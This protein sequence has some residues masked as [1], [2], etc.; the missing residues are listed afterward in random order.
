MPLPSICRPSILP[1]FG[2]SC[3]SDDR[4]RERKPLC[5]ICMGRRRAN[6][7]RSGL[8]DEQ[9]THRVRTAGVASEPHGHAITGPDYGIIAGRVH[10][11]WNL[12]P[13]DSS[14]AGRESQS[15]PRA[16]VWDCGGVFGASSRAGN[17]E[18]HVSSGRAWKPSCACEWPA[19]RLTTA[20]RSRTG[21]PYCNGAE[22][23]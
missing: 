3:L 6:Q 11:S 5:M 16:R 2:S 18:P 19:A 8:D 23:K 20:V 4:P 22:G 7:R 10:A 21:R 9:R 13:D 1:T 15:S 14:R 12:A 17:W